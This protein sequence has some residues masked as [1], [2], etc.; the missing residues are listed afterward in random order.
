M[1]CGFASL[2]DEKI[3]EKRADLSGYLNT[4]DTELK[5]LGLEMTRL[6]VARTR[7]K[8]QTI[9]GDELV[10][11]LEEIEGRF[12]DEIRSLTFLYVAPDKRQYLS[13]TDLFGEEFKN[14]FPT[15]NAEVIEAGNCF[16]LGRFTA[17]VYHLCRAMEIGLRVL[18]V[19]LGMP[20]RIWSTTKWNHILDRIKGK[21][22]KNN[23]TLAHDYTWQS[24]R[25]FYENAHAFLA[26]VRVPIRNS[27]MHVESVYD[28]TGAE[29]VL[30][31]VKT[32]MRHLAAK[33]SEVR[34]RPGS[35]ID[36]LPRTKKS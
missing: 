24:D 6:S 17:C 1:H 21:I 33:L 5:F 10:E 15:A 16:A 8:I 18:F 7:T 25:G 14:K 30:G 34:A 2:H 12:N 29:N 9:T 22:D 20:P 27:T 32:F 26:A 23:K 35:G 31:S 11:A 36:S 13:K 4:M 3:S 19:S 28:E